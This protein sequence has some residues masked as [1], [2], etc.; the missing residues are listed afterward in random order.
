QTRSRE[1]LDPADRP[2]QAHEEARPLAAGS[3]VDPAPTL[4][5]PDRV[6]S[7]D[8]LKRHQ[9]RDELENVRGATGRQRQRRNAQEQD[10]DE[11]EA[12]LLEDLDQAAE[13]L[14]AVTR[15]PALDLIADLLR[16]APGVRHI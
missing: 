11:R 4:G 5:Q 3:E 7:D 15:Q 14:L 13:R 2:G 16:R 12:L 6:P 8:Q 10:E 9:D 1:A